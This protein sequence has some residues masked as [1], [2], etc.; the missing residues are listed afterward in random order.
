MYDENVKGAI[1]IS[2]LNKFI[3]AYDVS[4]ASKVEFSDFK[5]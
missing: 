2:P 3:C 1:Y 4:V 5:K